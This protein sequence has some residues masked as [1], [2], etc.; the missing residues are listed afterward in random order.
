M[1]TYLGAAS[2]VSPEEVAGKNF[3]GAA[4]VHVEG[5]LLF[6]SDLIFETLRSAK[7]SGAL[8]SLDL[9]SFTVVEASKPYLEKLVDEFVDILIANE[10]EALAYTGKDDEIKAVEKLSER[11]DIGILK[12]GPRG[13]YISRNGGVIKVEAKGSGAAIDTTGAGDLWA[14]GFLFG[15]ANGYALEKC[16]EL[17]SAC[18]YEVCQVVGTKIPEDGWQRIRKLLE[19]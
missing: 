14:S 12:V 2:E 4:I 7:S 18:G 16:G 6:N 1:F 13:S 10:D 3:E 19:E 8:V 11:V 17:G 9:A 15:L 5:Y